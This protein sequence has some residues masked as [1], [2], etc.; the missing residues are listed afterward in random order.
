V[1]ELAVDPS[2]LPDLA[3]E[4]LGDGRRCAVATLVEVEGSA[5]FSPGAAMLIGA[6]GVIEGSV[7]GGCVEAAL[8][9]EAE[10]VLAGGPPRVLAYGISDDL[11]GTVGLMCG[12]AVDVFLAELPPASAPALE[13]VRAAVANDRPAGLVTLVDGPSAGAALAVTE[14]GAVGGLGAG[15][16]L[17]R[18]TAGDAAALMEQGVSLLRRYGADGSRMADDL[19]VFIHSFAQRSRMVIFGAVDFSIALARLAREVGYRVT[20]CDP[21]EAF[22]SGSRFAA[23][24]EVVTAWPDTY[25]DEQAL[26]ERDAVLIFTHDR[27][28]DEPA[29]LAAL[30]SG[31]GYI[32]ALGSRKTHADRSAR[33]RALGVSEEQLRTIVSPCGLDIGSSTPAQTAVSILAEIMALRAGRG[34]G[35]LLEASGPIR[36]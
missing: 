15:E 18:S 21:R 3:L 13:A 11:A 8:A 34:G 35:R 20:I 9:L 30:R 19:R 32:G 36:S 10:D 5:P 1:T 33:L 16:Q 31:A 2:V 28:L 14:G 25:L 23:A 29:A 6:D 22:S 24:A 17:D 26:S 7:T 12:G 4:W 27:K